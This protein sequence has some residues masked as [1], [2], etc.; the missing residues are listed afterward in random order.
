MRVMARFGLS[1]EPDKSFPFVVHRKA[2]PLSIS[3]KIH[4]MLQDV[5]LHYKGL[6]KRALSQGPC[7]NITNGF[8]DFTHFQNIVLQGI[9]ST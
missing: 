1:A 3:L 6:V 2:H 4:D 7:P 5:T 9:K 8:K